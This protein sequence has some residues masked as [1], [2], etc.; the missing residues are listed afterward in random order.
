MNLDFNV[1]SIILLLSGGLTLFI[2][3]LLHQ[4]LE[5]S[6]K[7]FSYIMIA[8]S[9][10]AIA[11]SIQLSSSN[12]YQILFC[13]YLQYIG[14]ATTPAL[15]QIAVI[16]FIGKDKWLSNRNLFF[17]FLIPGIT[18]LLLYSN[19]FHYLYYSSISL[20]RYGELTFM[21][22]EKGP[23]YI[24]HMAY[25]YVMLLWGLYLLIYEFRSADGIYKR[26]RN[27]IV[28]G[29]IAPWIFNILYQLGIKPYQY[30]D[31]T[32]YSFILTS[33]IASYG[34]FRFKLF[35]ISPI[36]KEMVFDA[37][38]QGALVLDRQRRVVGL[39]IEMKKILQ[40]GSEVIGEAFSTLFPDQQDLQLEV[41]QAK[42]GKI[43]VKLPEGEK[44]R[45]FSVEVSQLFENG[46]FTGTVVLFKDVTAFYAGE[47]IRALMQRKDDFL[48][49]ASHE[50]KTPLT[51]LKGYL[52]IA[53]N[54]AKKEGSEQTSE[55]IK[56]AEKQ[57]DKLAAL[58]KDLLDVSKIEAGRMEYHFSEFP[59]KE[60]LEDCIDFANNDSVNHIVMMEGD[61]DTPIK[62]DRN[63]I[64]Q[65]VCNLLSNAIKYSP[66]SPVVTIRVKKDLDN[67]I[68]SVKDNGIGVPLD[69]QS[70]LFL[71]F[72]RVEKTEQKFSGLGIG[73]FIAHEIIEKH[74]GKMWLESEPGKGSTFSFSLPLEN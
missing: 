50:L 5:K 73:L 49:I 38:Q 28:L 32:P 16:K 10:W 48:S 53:A 17:L 66:E 20:V 36:A 60:V 43:E 61:I 30:L 6:A 57:A 72:Y 7:P 34:F 40:R 15:W 68:V 45:I 35:N 44:E 22:V 46:I 54:S 64:E 62:A 13:T 24:V 23:W 29:A 70:N 56:R 19:R 41:F 69:K 55:F 3:F 65:V 11:Y 59:L 1:F 63:R 2:A 27:I 52:K 47:R 14:T 67:C 26:Q 51:T 74:G 31:L 9:V 39:N 12:Y 42:S 33:I 18:L 21:K 25:F 37:M 58:I 8:I 71:K 4:K